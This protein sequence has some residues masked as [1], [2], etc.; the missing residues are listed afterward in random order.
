MA[1]R[2]A[3]KA[4]AAAEPPSSHDSLPSYKA[5]AS[6]GS[7]PPQSPHERAAA[8]AVA[9]VEQE[10]A[11]AAAAEAVAQAAVA[12]AEVPRVGGPGVASKRGH[13]MASRRAL[14]RL[15]SMSLDE[16]LDEYYGQVR[17][18]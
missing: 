10:A 17:S 1:Q 2:A 4:A 15:Q 3:L 14:T 11:A 6:A 12:A 9:E 16:Q 7:S 5:P 8:E 18:Q 13:A